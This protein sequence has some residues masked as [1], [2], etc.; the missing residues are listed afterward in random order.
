MWPQGAWGVIVK[1]PRFPSG[2]RNLRKMKRRLAN[3][4]GDI[5]HFLEEMGKSRSHSIEDRVKM[6]KK[7]L[8]TRYTL[9][10]SWSKETFSQELDDID[11]NEIFFSEEKMKRIINDY[12][13][14]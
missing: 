2:N 4:Y 5:I 11:W 7:L 6:R 13:E 9:D 12:F 10:L 8:G 1:S 3:S 14:D